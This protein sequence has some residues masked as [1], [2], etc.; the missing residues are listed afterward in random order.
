A[1]EVK[2]AHGL[3]FSVRMGLNSGEVVVGKIGDDLRMDYTAQGHT[4]GLA[5][6]ME[7]LAAP[8]NAYLSEHTARLVSGFFNLRDLGEFDL[9]GLHAPIRVYDLDAADHPRTRFEAARVRGLSRFVGR[10]REMAVLEAA[11]EQGT[12]GPGQIVGVVAPPGV[13]KSR[14]CFEFVERCRARGVP[15]YET[16][17]V[18]HGKQVPLLPMLELFRAFFAITGRDVERVA[19]EKIADRLLLLDERLRGELPFVFDLLGVSDPEHPAPPM[20]PE[21]LQ[22]RL[23]AVARRIVQADGEREVGVMLVEDLHWIDA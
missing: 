3:D 7:Q 19:R 8:G 22:R 15:V 21:A 20:D 23:F 12:S 16:R 10:E 9:K 18:A 6:R 17:G 4:V 11:L 14:L 5:A 1:E 2:R 13:G